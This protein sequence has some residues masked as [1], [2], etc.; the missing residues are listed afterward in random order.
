[1]LAIRVVVD[2]NVLVAGLSG[3][4]GPNRKV[5]RRSLQGDLQSSSPRRTLRRHAETS[6]RTLYDDLAEAE[7][8]H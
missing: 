8:C 4:K 6:R 3:D 5:L 2:T 7:L 1:M